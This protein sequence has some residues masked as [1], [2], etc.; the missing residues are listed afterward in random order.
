MTAVIRRD[1]ELLLARRSD[2]GHWG[3]V[4]GI[5]DPGEDPGV[6]ARREALEETGV[7]IQVERLAAVSVDGPA[8][9]ANGDVSTYLD[10]TFACTWLD[11]EAHVAD[12]ESTEVGWFRADQL[13]DL[14]PALLRRIDA[15]LSRE[16]ACRFS[17]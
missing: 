11:G 15:A 8:V 14:R 16:T 6:A 10:H 13:P 5:V 7:H 3:P 1:R 9:H 12:D 4:T 17:A 2:N